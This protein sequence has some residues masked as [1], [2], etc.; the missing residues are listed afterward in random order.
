MDAED[1]SYNENDDDIDNYYNSNDNQNEVE[2]EEVKYF[3]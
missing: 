3:K 1:K 2:N